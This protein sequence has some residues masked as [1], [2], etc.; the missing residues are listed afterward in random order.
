MPENML[1][2]IQV[3]LSVALQCD[4]DT[5]VEWCDKEAH[6]RFS[7]LYPQINQVINNILEMNNESEN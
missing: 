2:Q 3:A 6:D 1:E 7:Q 4:L 5:G